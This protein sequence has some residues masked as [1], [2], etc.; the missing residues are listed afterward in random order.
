MRISVLNIL[1]H[2]AVLLVLVAWRGSGLPMSAGRAMRIT[3]SPAGSG[4]AS[5]AAEALPDGG[6]R[7][8]RAARR[9]QRGRQQQGKQLFQSC[10]LG[11]SSILL[12]D[13]FPAGAANQSGAPA[14]HFFVQNAV[15]QYVIFASIS[16]FALRTKLRISGSSGYRTTQPGVRMWPRPFRSVRH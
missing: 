16:S 14:V 9:Q 13:G 3:L 6:G 11:F 7:I 10:H 2:R 4:A 12:Y 1:V 5:G 8:R 15:F